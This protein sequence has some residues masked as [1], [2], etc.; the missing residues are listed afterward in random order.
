MKTPT[1]L[2]MKTATL[3]LLILALSLAPA[4]AATLALSGLPSTNAISTNDDLVLNTTNNGTGTWTTKRSRVQNLLSLVPAPSGGGITNNQTG[5]T[6]SGTFSGNGAGLTN[7][8]GAG[9]LSNNQAGVTLS[10]TFSGNGEGL[11]NAPTSA[12]FTNW[13]TQQIGLGASPST[14]FLLSSRFGVVGDMWIDANGCP[15]GTD[16]SAAYQALLDKYRGS[17]QPILIK[18]ERPSLIRT[19]LVARA[20]NI[21]MEGVAKGCGFYLASNCACPILWNGLKT[22]WDAYPVTNLTCRNLTFSGNAQN[23]RAET[24]FMYYSSTNAH[25]PGYTYPPPGIQFVHGDWITFQDCILTNM[26]AVMPDYH[27]LCGFQDFFVDVNHLRFDHCEIYVQPAG[28]SDG[29][30]LWGP[31][32]DFDANENTMRISGSGGYPDAIIGANFAE[33]QDFSDIFTNWNIRPICGNFQVKKFHDEVNIPGTAGAGKAL[34]FNLEGSSDD[35]TST[36]FCRITNILIEDFY[37][38]FSDIEG[39]WGAPSPGG[40]IGN[41]T[42]KNAHNCAI[43]FPSFF[44]GN[45][46][47]DGFPCDSAIPANAKPSCYPQASS[48]YLAYNDWPHLPQILLDDTHTN[49]VIRGIQGNFTMGYSNAIVE[50]VRKNSGNDWWNIYP[51]TQPNVLIESANVTGD[52]PI[53][54]DAQQRLVTNGTN[55]PPFGK[56]TLGS[57]SSVADTVNRTNPPALVY[58]PGSGTNAGKFLRDDGTYQAVSGGAVTSNSVVTALT[59]V[60]LGPA[61]DAS[62]IVSGQIPVGRLWDYATNG[63]GGYL[64]QT[65]G[66]LRHSTFDGQSL[67]N[68]QPSAIAAG[69]AANLTAGTALSANTISGNQGITNGHTVAVR[70]LGDFG[71]SNASANGR[72]QYTNATGSLYATGLVQRLEGG[73]TNTLVLSGGNV[74]IKRASASYSL[75]VNGNL[76]CAGIYNSSAFQ[77]G[78]DYGI[79]WSGR[80]EIYSPLD[81]YVLFGKSSQSAPASLVLGIYPSGNTSWKTNALVMSAT[82]TNNVTLTLQAGTNTSNYASLVASNAT[83]S[84]VVFP[85]NGIVLRQLAIIPTNSIPASDVGNGITNFLEINMTNTYNGGGRML[86]WTNNV[87]GGIFSRKTVQSDTQL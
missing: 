58:G 82:T 86:L 6:L 52:S 8:P 17:N 73:G 21:T 40:W 26:G 80:A 2:A 54:A 72:L 34:S 77:N 60:P 59:Y 45:T 47:I 25:V 28:R 57:I 14:N 29:W 65:S 31:I 24:W 12:A 68:I 10:G 13:V 81:G 38:S 84:G 75:D 42:I 16:D 37:G 70:F 56:L 71:V 36:N 19:S 74:S 18:V 78:G 43:L 87:S 27:G 48:P 51:A 20:N 9:G 53:Y 46:T 55:Q 83:L 50:L 32:G 79:T 5:V 44:I 49:V 35:W 69:T 33:G 15:Q 63:A 11:S 66:G 30:H 67:S 39:R 41:L 1:F 23:Q 76:G 61:M 7:V 4:A 62:N 3:L 22:N 64:L 85:T